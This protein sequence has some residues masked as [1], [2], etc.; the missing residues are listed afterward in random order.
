MLAAI[1]VIASLVYL[2]VQGRQSSV[3]IKASMNH[4]LAS[5][6]QITSPSWA[7]HASAVMRFLEQD[8][9]SPADVFVVQQLIQANFRSYENY[10]YQ[11]KVGLFD[12]IEWVGI[13]R[14]MYRQLSNPQVSSEWES[15]RSEFSDDL[16]TLIDVRLAQTGD[17]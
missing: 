2:A 12:E 9:H 14:T 17:S 5:Q 13:Q 11:C 8:N 4:S 3:L 7:G 15:S 1:G 6:T 16:R 10:L